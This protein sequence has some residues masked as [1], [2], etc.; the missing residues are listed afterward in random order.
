LWWDGISLLAWVAPDGDSVTLPATVKHIFLTFLVC[1]DT[2]RQLRP[3]ERRPM[4]TSGWPPPTPASSRTHEF[5]TPTCLG[6]RIDPRISSADLLSAIEPTI[7]GRLAYFVI[8]IDASGDVKLARQVKTDSTR[9]ASRVLA[10]M[11]TAFVA[12][13]AGEAD[14]FL[15]FG[16]A[17][18][19]A[20]SSR[21]QIE[22]IRL[23]ADGNCPWL[24]P[25][26]DGRGP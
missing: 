20:S 5:S 10:R 16:W 9:F 3:A 21:D 25:P 17:N 6:R 1:R 24:C 13:S 7:A 18:A 12:T 22:L 15:L 4:S 14:E 26:Q 11:R 19:S 2:S 23:G 8:R